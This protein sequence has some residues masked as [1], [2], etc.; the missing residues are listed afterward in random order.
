MLAVW[1]SLLIL[2][3]TVH[4]TEFKILSDLLHCK[5][6]ELNLCETLLLGVDWVEFREQLHLTLS[7]CTNA[8]QQQIYW[9][10]SVK[11]LVPFRA[12]D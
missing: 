2:S 6:V 7:L 12:F 10:I 8:G 5:L 4:Q 1:D 11:F 3:L 9:L